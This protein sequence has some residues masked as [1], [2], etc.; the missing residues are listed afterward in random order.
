MREADWTYA[1]YFSMDGSGWESADSGKG[2]KPDAVKQSLPAPP[3]VEYELYNIQSDPGQMNNLL[4]WKA[5]EDVRKEWARLHDKLTTHLFDAG[6]LPNG[7]QWP[8]WPAQA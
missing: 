6:N 1:V 4:H 7:F 2:E 8:I 3:Q 5:T